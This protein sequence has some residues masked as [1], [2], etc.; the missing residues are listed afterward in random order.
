MSNCKLWIF[1]QEWERQINGQKAKVLL[2]LS[3][4]LLS[5]AE[6]HMM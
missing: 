2:F 5:K 3:S 6:I 4:H 1:L